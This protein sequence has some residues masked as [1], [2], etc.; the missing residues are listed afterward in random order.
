MR[1]VLF[2]CSI[3]RDENETISRGRSL[4][5]TLRVIFANSSN[6]MIN[7]FEIKSHECLSLCEKPNA[8]AFSADGKASYLFANV[9]PVKNLE[10][11]LE[12]AKLYVAQDDGWI[13]DARACGKLRFCLVGRIPALGSITP[14]NFIK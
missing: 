3:C 2:I 11:I 9:D 4:A 8:I 1:H 13:D 5:N 10:D 14:T 6:P 12:F 7:D